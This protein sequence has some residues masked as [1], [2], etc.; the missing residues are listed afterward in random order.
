MQK[1]GPRRAI[2]LLRRQWD[3]VAVLVLTAVATALA[4]GPFLGRTDWPRSGDLAGHLVTISWLRD[5]GLHSWAFGWYGGFPLFYFYFPLPAAIGALLG[6]IV[7]PGTAMRIL[8]LIGTVALPPSVVYL[9]RGGGASRTDAFAAGAGAILFL[10]LHFLTVLGGTFEAAAIGEYSYSI[11]LVL[12]LLYL[13][14]LWPGRFSRR[15]LV[16]CAVLLAAIALSHLI[17]LALVLAASGA[18]LVRNRL[19]PARLVIGSWVVGLLL[20]AFWSLPFLLRMPHMAEIW[21]HGQDSSTLVP[22]VIQGAPL[23]VLALLGI[24]MDR[25]PARSLAPLGILAAAGLLP[26]VLPVPF[27][28]YRGLPVFFLGLAVFAAV[29]VINVVSAVRTLR[30]PIRVCLW[31]LCLVAFGAVLAVTPSRSTTMARYLGGDLTVRDEHAWQAMRSAL[32]LL[33]PGPVLSVN[34]PE[35]QANSDPS[36]SLFHRAGMSQLP[37]MDG[38]RSLDGMLQE[39]APV[40]QYVRAAKRNLGGDARG[41]VRPFGAAK[42]EFKVGVAQAAALGVRYLVLSGSPLDAAQSHPSLQTRARSTDWMIAELPRAATVLVLDSVPADP[43]PSEARCR[44]WFSAIRPAGHGLPPGLIRG[45]LTEEAVD[46]RNGGIR[47]RTE[48]PGRPHLIRLSYFPGW[49]LETPGDG[50][51]RFGPNQMLI[52]PET[53]EVALAFAPG[54]DV[55]TGRVVSLIGLVLVLGL[56]LPWRTR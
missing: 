42:P 3:Y 55:L 14:T 7:G 51:Y 46:L 19:T 17:V 31:G 35:D 32:N 24:S 37:V 47:F 9:A 8:V 48:S 28:P 44:E 20:S 53:S 29:S 41:L 2:S 26:L 10:H 43:C 56:A 54:R 34:I 15:R 38:R 5:L 25:R 50:P 40:S 36:V 45:V 52:V 1:A 30:A 27:F 6:G 12:G 39:S 23:A 18:V 4:M 49:R 33:P 16:A 21:W 11:A 22:L 13:G